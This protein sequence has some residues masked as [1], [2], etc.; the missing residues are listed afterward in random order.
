MPTD[1]PC[2]ALP[3]LARRHAA[4]ALTGT[5]AAAALLCTPAA[6]AASSQRCSAAA[7]AS[8]ELVVRGISCS[9]ADRVIKA[10]LKKPGCT[11]TSAQSER[12]EGCKGSTRVRGF[13]CTGLFPGEGFDL[14]CR[15]GSR[16]ITASAGG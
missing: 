1:G 7:Y 15:A 4:A 6:H 5:L 16:R 3:V 14:R 2:L 8:G 13:R 12:G 10:A 9:G 11:P